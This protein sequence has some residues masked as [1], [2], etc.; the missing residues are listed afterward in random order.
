MPVDFTDIAQCF[1]KR[2]YIL[3]LHASD[4]AAE[5]LITSREIEEAMVV[6]QII[7][8]YSDDK[9]GPSCL[10]MGVTLLGRVLHIQV[11][12]PPSC[13]VITLYEPSQDHW[14]SDHKTRKQP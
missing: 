12:Y 1:A 2:E 11:S 4:R 10:I 14:E 8:D 7:E 13:K 3:T 9:Y 6:G 5:R